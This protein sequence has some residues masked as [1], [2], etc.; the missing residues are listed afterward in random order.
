MKNR[1]SFVMSATLL[2][3]LLGGC[4][5]PEEKKNPETERPLSTEVVTDSSTHI[6][7]TL[8]DYHY[9]QADVKGKPDALLDAYTS[10]TLPI[11]VEDTVSIFAP[12]D[13]GEGTIKNTEEGSLLTTKVG[14]RFYI[15]PYR[16]LFEKEDEIQRKKNDEISNLLSRYVRDNQDAPV[17][18][19][20]IINQEDAVQM[21]GIL[22]RKLGVNLDPVLQNYIAMPAKAIMD[23]QQELLKKDQEATEKNYDPFGKA[24][25]LE[26]LCPE[27]DACFLSFTFEYQGV[28]I[29]NGSPTVSYID[30]VLP[31]NPVTLSVLITR[32]GLQTFDGQAL[33]HVGQSSHHG[34]ILTAE[35]AV[36]KYRQKYNL[37]IP[38]EGDVMRVSS[39]Y[40]EYIPIVGESGSILTPYWC[41]PVEME[42]P[43]GWYVVHSER[44]NAFTGEDITYGG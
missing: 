30:G 29:Y 27:D 11:S 36:D 12:E 44:F 18:D 37:V 9:I 22:L 32:Q 14:N 6:D 15:S 7:F 5:T 23:Y 39:I 25:L 35:D 19:P 42:L 3:L 38:P 34:S 28:P 26:N 31:P 33:F 2:L 43:I 1:A 40:L 20:G 16:V 10:E 41:F 4:A 21:V 8:N 24:F 17:Q 13:S